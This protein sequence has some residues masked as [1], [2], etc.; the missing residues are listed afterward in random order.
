[1]NRRTTLRLRLLAFVSIVALCAAG[2]AQDAKRETGAKTHASQA[3]GQR[4]IQLGGNEC[5]L[6]LRVNGCEQLWFALDTGAGNTVVSTSTAGALGLKMEGGH[7]TQ[8]AG[9]HVPSSTARG[10]R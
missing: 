4:P 2:Q 5:S 10:L 3:V 1:M 9:G 6:R 7:R 8:G